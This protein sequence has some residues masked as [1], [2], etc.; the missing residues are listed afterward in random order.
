MLVLRKL[1]DAKAHFLL[2]SITVRTEGARV[3]FPMTS[4]G[5]NLVLNLEQICM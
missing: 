5:G 1:E 4:N 3:F 2:F